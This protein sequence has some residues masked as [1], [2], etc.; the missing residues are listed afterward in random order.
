MVSSRAAAASAIQDG[1]VQVTGTPLP[2]PSTLI[3]TGTGVSITEADHKFVSRGGV[4]LEGAL[5][6]FSVDVSDARAIDVG[7]STGGFTDCLLQKG[8]ASVVAL[9]VGYGQLHWKLRSDKRVTVVERTNIRHADAVGL[10]APFDVVVA[11]L[12]FISL[13]TVA[14]ALVALGHHP[15]D[16][17]LLVKPQ[18]EAGRPDVGKGG[19][20]RDD[21]VR[22]AAVHDTIDGLAEEGLGAID[23]VA[24]PIRGAKGNKEVVGRF[25]LGAATVGPA[26]VREVAT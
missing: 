7:A 25:R 26:R 19:I 8:A 11:D 10:G 12:S 18:F 14:S 6:A 2:K 9:D 5:E 4:K 22:I 13:R 3:D 16:Y 17:I 1:R 21:A 20:V 23:L 24:S 15:T